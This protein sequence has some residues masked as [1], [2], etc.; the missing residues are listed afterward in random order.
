MTRRTHPV[1]ATAA[2]LLLLSSLA[3][4][5]AQAAV[6]TL[7]G[8]TFELRYDDTQL[9]LF[10]APVLAGD[11][12]FFTFAGFS[13]E[14]ANGA[15]LRPASSALSGIELIARSGWRIGALAL[16]VFG[17]YN[18]LG[19]GSRVGVSGAMS[20]FDLADASR[21]AT[22]AL[23]ISAATPLDLA[24]G[25]NHDWLASAAVDATSAATGGNPFSAGAT[26]LGLSLT[27]R[28]EA[29]TV[30][31]PGARQ[32]FIEQKFAGVALSVSSFAVPAPDSFGLASAGLAAVLWAGRCRGR[33]AGA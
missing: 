8:S 30:A 21:S 20:A 31:G 23:A 16:S 10:G 14:S 9:G 18:L 5:P 12:L 25:A 6:V 7:A 17:D 1:V 13:A 3:T 26:G 28:L 4:M 19:A 2:G 33:R 15:G 29:E 11:Q 22:T 32:A 27:S 24:D